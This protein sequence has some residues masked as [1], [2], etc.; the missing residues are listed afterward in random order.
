LALLTA[1][2]L[3]KENRQFLDKLVEAKYCF[4]EMPRANATGASHGRPTTRASAL[5][6]GMAL[7]W[8]RKPLKSLKTDSEMA[9]RQLAVAGKQNRSD[10]CHVRAEGPQALSFS[11]SHSR[12]RSCTP[13]SRR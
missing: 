4:S 6:T 7:K 3:D 5:R 11:L 1:V 2:T 13:I 10:E 9:I 12:S 8:R